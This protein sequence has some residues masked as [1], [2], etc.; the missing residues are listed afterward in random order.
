[1]NKELT[2]TDQPTKDQQ[3]EAAGYIVEVALRVFHATEGIPM[4]VILAGAHAAVVTMMVEELGG[5]MAAASCERAAERVRTL[6]SREAL[7]LAVT[8]P[9]GQ[10]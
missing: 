10:A 2:M 3:A 1:M 4:H 9:A 5:P 6:P 7:R 8:P